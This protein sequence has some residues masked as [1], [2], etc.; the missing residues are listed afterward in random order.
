[1]VDGIYRQLSLTQA[2]ASLRDR[3][4][5]LQGSG[6]RV[7]Q[8]PSPPAKPHSLALTFLIGG[9]LLGVVLAAAAAGAATLARQVF[10]TPGEA[11][12]ALRLPNLAHF[13][14]RESNM[15]TPEGRAAIS[16]FATLLVDATVDGGLL[17]VIQFVSTET[18]GKSDFALELG[19]AMAEEQSQRTLLVDFDAEARYRKLSDKSPALR[20]LD[21]ASSTLT[22]ARSA[23]AK[24]W[25]TLDA[26][27]SPFGDPRLPLAE[28]QAALEAIRP[29]FD[30]ILIVARRDVN[31]YAARRLY[32]LADV[33][34]LMV[35]AERTRSP[36]ARQL[37]ETVLAAG[38]D[39]LGFVFTHRGYYV[40]EVLYRWL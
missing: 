20:T 21:A 26:A 9:V 39:I 24:L 38:G 23:T 15:R 4:D 29:H 2:G 22:V 32:A 27:K 34:V 40:P 14:V 7:I 13:D 10:I 5:V 6:F 18:D 37:K 11:A 33:N 25:L 8:P 1:V 17:K 31:Q 16:R 3:A 30:R 12:R 35:R 36:A 19:R 28:V